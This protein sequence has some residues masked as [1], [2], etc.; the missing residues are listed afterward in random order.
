MIKKILLIC[1]MTWL[2]LP[3]SA[4][5]V[6]TPHF[7]KQTPPVP[8][9]TLAKQLI[10]PLCLYGFSVGYSHRLRS[11][12][13]AA[14]HLTRERLSIADTLGRTDQFHAEQKL[15]HSSRVQL[16]EM[17]VY[18]YDRGHLA[19][20][21]DMANTNAQ[22][23]SFSLANVVLQKRQHN[24]KHWADVERLT[25]YQVYTHGE[26]Y[27]VTGVAFINADVAPTGLLIPSHLFKAVYIPKLQAA[28]VYWSKNANANHTQVISLA[29][30]QQKTGINA[31]PALGSHI[32]ETAMPL[33]LSS[34]QPHA[35]NAEKTQ[36]NTNDTQTDLL[37]AFWQFVIEL[38]ALLVTLFW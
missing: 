3:A 8:T 17:K 16:A 31:M 4:Q 15:P 23:D 20:H 19:P 36:E 27:V 29:E 32:K 6:C 30:L 12:V 25:R 35:D 5:P 21:H 24:R 14:E 22:F 10:T 38:F 33:P 7:F 11:P 1:A 26:A 18:G 28:G 9:D 13:W 37:A 2:V 34:Q